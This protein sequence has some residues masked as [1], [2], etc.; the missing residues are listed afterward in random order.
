MW[1]DHKLLDQLLLKKFI[2]PM[3]Y[4]H[5]TSTKLYMGCIRAEFLELLKKKKIKS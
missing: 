4:K 1:N 3:I 5:L 2:N